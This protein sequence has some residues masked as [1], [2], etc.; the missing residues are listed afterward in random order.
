MN[1]KFQASENGPKQRYKLERYNLEA[2]RYL[3]PFH[4]VNGPGVANGPGG[5]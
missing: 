1:F 4:I 5:M 2:K 3:A